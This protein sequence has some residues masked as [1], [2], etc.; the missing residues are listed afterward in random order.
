MYQ[1]QPLTYRHALFFTG[2]RPTADMQ[3]P[4][5]ELMDANKLTAAISH[6]I[7]VML[8]VG[9]LGMTADHGFI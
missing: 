5:N 9:A 3:Y 1:N 7:V 2:E 6:V 8:R 4:Q